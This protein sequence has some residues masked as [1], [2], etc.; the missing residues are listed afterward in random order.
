MD[1]LAEA[2]A[3]SNATMLN[4]VEEVRRETAARDRKVD[5]L[6]RSL[7]Q[8][9]WLTVLLGVA[10][11]MLLT[12]GVINAVNLNSNRDTNRV[13]LDCVNGV[14]TCGQVNRANQDRLLDEVKRYNLIGFF[15]IRN[16]P[17]SED[18]KA[19]K[20]VQCMNRLYPGGPQLPAQR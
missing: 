7:K 4:L 16:N 3:A 18:P 9:R 15:C 19:E 11:A 5:A 20:F 1:H 12:L 17:A 14:G 8:M 2:N 10:I 6:D 13:V